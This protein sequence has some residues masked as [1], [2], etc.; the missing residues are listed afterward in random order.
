MTTSADA[1]LLAMHSILLYLF[2]NI[3]VIGEPSLLLLL[4]SNRVC[5]TVVVPPGLHEFRKQ[6][7]N[8]FRLQFA[9]ETVKNYS[10]TWTELEQ[11]NLKRDIQ[12]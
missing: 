3:L 11:K 9:L 12:Q 6:R 5:H 1:P 10:K 2:H 8:F 4:R 7:I